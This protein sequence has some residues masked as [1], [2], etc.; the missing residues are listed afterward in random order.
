MTHLQE[1]ISMLAIQSRARSKR[2]G[3]TRLLRARLFSVFVI[4][5]LARP[6]RQPLPYSRYLSLFRRRV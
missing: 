4:A 2:L 1:V 3:V 5:A 6:A